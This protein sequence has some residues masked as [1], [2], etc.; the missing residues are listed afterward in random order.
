MPALQPVYGYSSDMEAAHTTFRRAEQG[1]VFFVAD[2]EVDLQQVISATLPA[3]TPEVTFEGMTSLCHA[4]RN[5][6]PLPSALA[7]GGGRAAG[8]PAE[9]AHRCRGSWTGLNISLHSRAMQSRSKKRML[10]RLRPAWQLRRQV[11][12]RCAVHDSNMMQY[13]SGHT[14][15]G[16]CRA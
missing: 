2:R 5:L 7:G 4:F 14:E 11:S 10:R 12:Q 9:P 3:A 8:H 6:S 16:V 15:G 1:G 13:C